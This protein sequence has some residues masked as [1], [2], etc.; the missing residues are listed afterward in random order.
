MLLVGV[1]ITPDQAAKALS[2]YTKEINDNPPENDPIK[3]AQQKS[4]IEF[5]TNIV[6]A[7]IPEARGLVQTIATA[8]DPLK[9]KNPQI[10]NLTTET[11]PVLR[12]LFEDY[13]SDLELFVPYHGNFDAV[14]EV[15][16]DLDLSDDDE[17]D[18]D[19]YIEHLKSFSR[20][21]LENYKTKVGPFL[22]FLQEK[23]PEENEDL[24]PEL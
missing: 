14:R 4:W 19:E 23:F 20:E 11:G 13:I 3:K 21:D 2:F 15:S 8:T 9:I 24:N 17:D 7:K 16:D 1:Y 18:D 22:R 12:E 10:A 5:L 6:E